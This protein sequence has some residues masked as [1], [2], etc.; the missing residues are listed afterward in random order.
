L[1]KYAHRYADLVDGRL[2][3]FGMP[4]QRHGEVCS[5]ANRLLETDSKPA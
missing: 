1:E 4:S 3:E 2:V 5:E